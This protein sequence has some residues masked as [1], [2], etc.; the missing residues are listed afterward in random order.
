M[1]QSFK[2]DYKDLC[3]NRRTAKGFCGNR[4]T[5]AKRW[6]AEAQHNAYYQQEWSVAL[7]NLESMANVTLTATIHGWYEGYS[8]NGWEG[9]GEH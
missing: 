7:W 9:Q 2:S 4:R 6:I 5:A 1:P 3:G 8:A